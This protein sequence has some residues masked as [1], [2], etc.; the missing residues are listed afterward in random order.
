M[1]NEEN[2][3]WRIFVQTGNP[4]AFNLYSESEKQQRKTEEELR[5]TEEKE[6][7]SFS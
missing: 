6:N 7:N 2:D 1:Q 4:I 3:L 5:K